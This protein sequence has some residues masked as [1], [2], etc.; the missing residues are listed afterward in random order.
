MDGLLNIHTLQGSLSVD[1]AQCN[2]TVQRGESLAFRERLN[3][4]EGSVTR[5]CP[6]KSVFT[7][8]HVRIGWQIDQFM[9]NMSRNIGEVNDVAYRFLKFLVF[10]CIFNLIPLNTAVKYFYFMY[11]SLIDT[12]SCL[13]DYLKFYK[14][15]S[16]T[17]IIKA[18]S[19]K[20]IYN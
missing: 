20:S 15:L 19:I 6:K 4:K 1:A 8:L 11:N 7:S 13:R 2:V 10:S 17:L 18:L 5:V 12:S 16:S 14:V 3:R 9:Y